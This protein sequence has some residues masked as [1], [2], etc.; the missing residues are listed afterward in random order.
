[1]Q[2][3]ESIIG[4][5]DLGSHELRKKVERLGSVE[6]FNKYDP[7]SKTGAFDS[8]DMDKMVRTIEKEASLL[9]QTIRGLMAPESQRTYQ[10]QR[11][12]TA[13]IVTIVSVLCFSQ[14]QN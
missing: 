6:P 3:R 13:R 5:L 12:S 7:T 10:R 2:I 9:L 8:L 1:M 11:E 4:T 14:R